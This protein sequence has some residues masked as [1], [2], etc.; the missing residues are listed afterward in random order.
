[1]TTATIFSFTITMLPASPTAHDNVY[2]R[3]L[4]LFVRERQSVQVEPKKI[5]A[6][7]CEVPSKKYDF[8]NILLLTD[9]ENGKSRIH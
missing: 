5:V 4:I 1:M 7:E 2:P 3:R 9:F 6:N 8:C